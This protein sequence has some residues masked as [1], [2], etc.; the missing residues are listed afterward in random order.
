M[1]GETATR[2][3][4]RHSHLY[5][6]ARGRI[7]GPGQGDCVLEFSDGALAFGTLDGPV[8]SVGAHRT[9]A[10]TEIPAKRWQIDAEDRHFRVRARLSATLR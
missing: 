2:L 9:A 8:L 1:A 10:G 6:G 7:E 4:V 3:T 5:P